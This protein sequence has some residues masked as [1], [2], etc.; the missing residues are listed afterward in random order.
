LGKY[1]LGKQ[2]MPVNLNFFS[3]VWIDEEGNMHYQAHNSHAGAF[4][5]LRAEMNVLVVLSNTPH[6]LSPDRVYAPKP[7]QLE[8]RKSILPTPDDP[9]RLFRPENGRGFQNTEIL[10]R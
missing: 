7:V 4:I 8:I 1:G 10:F 2:D 3:K 6:P 5:E 9:C